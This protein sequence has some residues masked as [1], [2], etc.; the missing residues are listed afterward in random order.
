MQG[1]RQAGLSAIECMITIG[2][3]AIV[4]AAL[5]ASFQI[6]QK[7]YSVQASLT[8]LT[9]NSRAGMDVIAREIRTAGYN[10]TRATTFNG[11]PY[12]SSNATLNLYQD[13]NG[14][15]DAA[16]TNEH[17]T[18]TFNSSTR[19]LSRSVNDNAGFLPFLT[20]V[21]VFTVNYLDQDGNAT[22]TT[23]NIRAVRITLTCRTA[24]ADPSWSQNGGYRTTTLNEVVAAKN[25]SYY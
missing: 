25:L 5:A 20:S 9:E 24:T 22:T 13:L 16:D 18:Y 17:I 21:T 1:S 11:I 10:P 23:A 14:D 15:G 6:Q 4:L 8:D 19:V 3:S 2:I 7:T 12:N